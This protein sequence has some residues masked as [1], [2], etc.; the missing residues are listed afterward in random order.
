MESYLTIVVNARVDI[1]INADIDKRK[2][3][4]HEATTLDSTH[5]D[6]KLPVAVGIFSPILMVALVLSS[7]RICGD[8]STRVLESLST[9]SNCAP[10]RP[11][12]E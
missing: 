5:P 1:D 3:R 12:M 7:A 8:C 4:V 11:V 2:L 9:A 10:G 6:W